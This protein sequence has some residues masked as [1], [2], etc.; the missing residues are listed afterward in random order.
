MT[1]RQAIEAVF[2]SLQQK[3]YE[4]VE[5]F[6]KRGRSRRFQIGIE[7]KSGSTRVEE[8]WA[9]RAGSARA[10]FF[11]AGTGAPDAGQSWPE[12]DGQPLGLPDAVPIPFWSPPADLGNSLVAENEAMALLNAMSRE[13]E[14]EL[15]GSRLIRGHLE[16][17]T[18]ET[19]I[20]STRGIQV[21]YRSRAASLFV[22]ILG[23]STNTGSITLSLAERDHSAFQP[24]A[25]AKRLANRLLLMKEGSAPARERGDVLIGAPVA[26]RILSSLLP[27]LQGPE[28]ESLALR[29]RDRRGRVG[30]DLVTV[31]DDGRLTGGLLESPADGEGLPTGPRVLLEEGRFRQ[32]LLDWRSSSG[33]QQP[34][35]GCA[36]RESWRDLPRTSPSH[37]YLRPAKEVS[38]GQLLG[39]V[40]RGYYLLEPLGAGVFDF[41]RDQFRLPVCGFVLR[42]GRAAGPLSRTWLEGGITVLLR[43]IQAVARDLTFEP[44]GAMI[45]SPSILVSGLGLRAP[46]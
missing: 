40:T 11:F 32:S 1:E 2:S 25:I 13:L 41:E 31:V 39:S 26:A 22:E 21:S 37:L 27:L 4:E 17:G 20:A 8:G 38:V 6:V 3:G 5:V 29:Y 28:A 35:P 18:S 12:P 45:G 36:R 44:L 30:S 43:N 16:E 19:S 24:G 14:N 9:V 23:P 10:S 34:A 33:R 7:G 46:D 42:Q 15:P